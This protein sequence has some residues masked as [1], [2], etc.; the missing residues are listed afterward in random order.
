ME[1]NTQSKLIKAATPLFATK[2]F[3][4]VTV[5]EL[6]EAAKVNGALIS[7]Y[8]SGKEGLY[9]AVLEEQFVPIIQMMQGLAATNHLSAMERLTQYARNIMIIHRQNPFLT[10]FIHSELVNPSACGGEVV[11]NYVSR[12]SQ[13]I[14]VILKD[15]VASSDFKPNFSLDYATVFFAGI[16]NYYYII[17]PFVNELAKLSD[18]SDEEYF[19]QAI[20]LFL[21]GIIGGRVHEQKN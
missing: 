20:H 10:Q 8:F 18:Q 5:R 14:Q 2:G 21:H 13:L 19:V 3:A 17:K 11:A 15:G 16:I 6:A 1:T 9:L 7:Y 12:L 4:A